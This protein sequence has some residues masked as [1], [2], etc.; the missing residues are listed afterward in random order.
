MVARQWWLGNEGLAMAVTAPIDAAGSSSQTA[1]ACVG[2]SKKKQTLN[3]I[4]K[5][6]FELHVAPLDLF[7]VS[8]LQA[9]QR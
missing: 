3:H 4:T 2:L 9:I 6:G 1:C 5:I 7:R 8:F